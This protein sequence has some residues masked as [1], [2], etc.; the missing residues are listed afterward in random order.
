MAP[1]LD[2]EIHRVPLLDR[3]NGPDGP[4][5]AYCAYGGDQPY[6]WSQNFDTGEKTPWVATGHVLSA[7]QIEAIY[8]EREQNRRDLEE[9]LERLQNGI[10]ETAFETISKTE[11][12]LRIILS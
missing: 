3:S 11:I 12:A 7:E 9:R 10:A 1:A 2:G 5:G 6:G 4:G 8:Q